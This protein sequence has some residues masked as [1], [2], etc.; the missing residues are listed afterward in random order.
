MITWDLSWTQQLTKTIIA[1][2]KKYYQNQLQDEECQYAILHLLK[3]ICQLAYCCLT[4]CCLVFTNSSSSNSNLTFS[5]S[6]KCLC[7][8]WCWSACEVQWLPSSSSSSW[9]QTSSSVLHNSG[10]FPYCFP[11]TSSSVYLYCL[12]IEPHTLGATNSLMGLCSFSTE[13][14]QICWA[15]CG[16]PWGE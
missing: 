12:I 13:P 9:S 5:T 3:G 11:T 7:H 16:K 2:I 6:V 1:Y 8:R 10:A 15:F 14:S 4:G